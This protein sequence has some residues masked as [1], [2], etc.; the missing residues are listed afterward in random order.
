M[1]TI[2]IAEDEKF[3]RR[4]LRTMIERS[5]I[6]TGEILE[7]RDGK[8]ALELLRTRQVDLLVTDIRRPRMDGIEL[9][10]HLG[11]LDH[12][13]MVL[14]VSGYDD[15]SYA[16]EMLRG[17][18]QDYLLKPVERE[19]L[20]QALEKLEERYCREQAAREERDRQFRRV[21]RQL[22]LEG[23]RSGEQRELLEKARGRFFAGAYVGV[24]AGACDLPAAEGA[25][26][27][28][29]PKIMIRS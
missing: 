18:A 16:V 29:G 6:P 26:C 12:Q 28:R 23:V 8:E 22:M 4:G 27:L 17:G 2:L 21:L 13:P 3:I 25:L 20:Y 10:S 5:P 7:A 14:V 1:N 24:C 19:R 15:F 9:V 11:N